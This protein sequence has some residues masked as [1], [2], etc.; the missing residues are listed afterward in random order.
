[1]PGTSLAYADFSRWVARCGRP[2]RCSYAEELQPF[3]AGFICGDCSAATEVIWPT[4]RTVEGIVR[5]LTMRPHP[6]NRNWRPGE[7][8]QDLMIENAQHG[9]FAGL[10]IDKPPGSPL[11][12]V[13]DAGI[14]V[15]ALPL[16]GEL[17]LAI[18]RM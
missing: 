5:L 18:G 2:E 7:T 8:L 12:V 15:D 17:T 11:L 4:A 10:G 14:R 6:A 1:V 3:Q 9:I 13:D 16:P